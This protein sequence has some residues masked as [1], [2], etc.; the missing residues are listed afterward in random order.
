MKSLVLAEKPSVAR[1]IARVLG[2]NRKNKH[3]IEGDRYIVTWALG[4]LMELKMPEDYDSGYKTWKMEDLPIIP[5][6]M[7]IKPIKNTRHQFQAIQQLAKRSDIKDFIIATDAGREGELVARW[8]LEKIKWKKPIQRLWISSQTDR[9]IRDGFRHLKPSKN[10][11]DLYQS[12]VCRAKADWL[13]GLNVSRALTTKYHDS[14]SAGRVQTPTLFLNYER[15]KLIKAFKPEPY[16]TIFATI[17]GIKATYKK[18]LYQEQ[19]VKDILAKTKDQRAVIKDITRKAKTERQPLPYDLTELQRDANRRFGFSAKKTSNVLQNLYERH[20]LVTYPR[21]D[22]RYLSQDMKQTMLDR[23][24]AVS[25]AFQQEVQPVLKNKGN[26]VAKS[27][28][29]DAKVTDHHAIIPT[30]QPVYFSDL[31]SDEQKLYRLIALRFLCLFYPSFKYEMIQVHLEIAGEQFQL[32]EKQIIEDGFKKLEKT[33]VEDSSLPLDQWRVGKTLSIQEVYSERKMTEPPLR[34]SE[35]DLLSKMEKYHLGT[36]ATRAE[37]IERLLS[38]ETIERTNDRLIVT[39]KGKQLIDLVHPSLKSPDLT[40]EWERKL[41]N[42]AK[43]KE[44]PDIFLKDI[45]NQTKQLIQD[46]KHS[47]QSYKLHNLTG[48]KCP[49]CGSLMKE[50]K[51]RNGKIL[52]CSNHECGHRKHKGPKLSNRRCPHCHKK[53]E[54]HQGKAG[55]YFQCKPCNVVQKADEKKKKVSKR[56]ERQLLNKYSQKNNSTVGNSLAD[57]LKQALEEKK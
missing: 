10:Y 11:H 13:I 19:E 47:D 31:D 4:H 29:N 22:S 49:E 21:T 23:L 46:I 15:E 5:K 25:S 30:E 53:M 45:V 37:I 8:I 24:K 33:R 35:A 27:V 1:E 43:G 9:A 34:F 52:V 6:H 26:V 3:Y 14:L 48:S 55:A 32:K 28:F 51:V 39:P 54:F 41:E 16:W 17:G 40:A 44:N 2:S 12:A 42:I 50:I 7:G 57:A 18:N 38:Q 20:K 56:E 36:P